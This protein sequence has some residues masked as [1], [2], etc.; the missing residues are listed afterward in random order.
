MSHR[1]YPKRDR[2]LHQVWR[3][4]VAPAPVV[5]TLTVDVAPALAAFRQAHASLVFGWHRDL[6]TL[7]ETL[8]NLYPEARSD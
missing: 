4:R 8:D 1:P 7:D 3:G 5:V 6:R 2:A